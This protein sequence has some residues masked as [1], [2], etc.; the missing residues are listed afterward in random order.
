M[1]HTWLDFR[2]LPIEELHAKIVPSR[3][4]ERH[5]TM[6][7]VQI[8]TKHLMEWI[9]S[10]LQWQWETLK[11]NFKWRTGSPAAFPWLGNFIFYSVRPVCLPL[12]TVDFALCCVHN[13]KLNL[14]RC[15]KYKAKQNTTKCCTVFWTFSKNQGQGKTCGSEF[16]DW[17]FTIRWVITG[18]FAYINWQGFPMAGSHLAFMD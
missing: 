1:L 18:L 17:G 5:Q 8:V 3:R 4:Q 2:E 15:K 12:G 11:V 10:Q 9:G 16:M 6:C 14:K 7:I 13:E